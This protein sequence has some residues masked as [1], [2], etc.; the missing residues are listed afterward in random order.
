MTAAVSSAVASVYRQLDPILHPQGCA[1]RCLTAEV[2]AQALQCRSCPYMLSRPT[3][4]VY[5]KLDEADQAHRLAR[6]AP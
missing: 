5:A 2:A 3:P 4:S 1:R 6:F